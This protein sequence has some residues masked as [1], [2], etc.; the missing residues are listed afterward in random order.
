MIQASLGFRS[1]LLFWSVLI[2]ISI[3]MV[4]FCLALAVNAFCERVT[5]E[6]LL[7]LVLNLSLA[8]VFSLPGH[9]SIHNTHTQAS[10]VERVILY[11]TVA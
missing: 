1:Y 6:L 4:V 9:I 11:M 8:Y 7:K 2:V 5:S 3:L 10:L